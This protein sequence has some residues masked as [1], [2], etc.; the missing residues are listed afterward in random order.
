MTRL[1]SSLAAAALLALAPTARAGDPVWQFKP[2]KTFTYECSSEFH[3]IQFTPR[4]EALTAG[5]SAPRGTAGPQVRP[6]GRSNAD[7]TRPEG[8]TT[9]EDPQWETV[10]LRGTVLAVGDDGTARI[11]FVVERVSIEVRFDITGV[12]ASWDSSKASR[13]DLAAFRPYQAMVGHTF[14]ALVGP[15]GTVKELSSADWPKADQTGTVRN[16]RNE[17]ENMAAD[18]VHA[19]TPAAVWLE[20]LFATAPRGGAAWEQTL[21]I[22]QEERLSVKADGTEAVGNHLCVK[23]RMKS[24]DKE[25]MIKP[26][27]LKTEG[28]SDVAKF[29][30]SMI[31]AAQKKG[32]AWFSRAEGALVKLDFE[33]AAEIGTGTSVTHATMKW[34]IEM[35]KQG[36]VD[37]KP[38][39]TDGPETPSK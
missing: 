10:V 28:A 15:D 7:P 6:G 25:R 22:P 26:E 14:R 3:Y 11:E 16:D 17:R 27:D 4:T 13:T 20:F 21:R 23:A 38:A 18:A 29:A 2:G 33:G 5:S 19:P 8:G 36:V 35:K 12:H 9:T 24:A 39:S 37:L 34:G 1:A 32:T 31:V 30:S